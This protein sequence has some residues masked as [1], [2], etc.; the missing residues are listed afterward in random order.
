MEPICMNDPIV[1][2]GLPVLVG[3][4]THANPRPL[5]IE[6]GTMAI[7]ENSLPSVVTAGIIHGV[8]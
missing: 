1:V 2:S 6:I 7:D 8:S 4:R 3:E 5:A